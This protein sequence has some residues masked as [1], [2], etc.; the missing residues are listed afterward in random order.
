MEKL[1]P[2]VDLTKRLRKECPWDREQ[3]HESLK[4][5]LIEESYEV[6]EALE[7][8]D[9]GRMRE[10][11][12]DLLL[13]VLFHA[14]IAE[15]S[16]TFTLDDVASALMTKLVDRHPHIFGDTTVSGPG[17]VKENWEK[18]KM[19]EGRRSLLD[20][21]PRHLPG[22]L[23][24]LR[25]QEK[26][27]AGGFDWKRAGDV[28]GKVEEEMRE[29][30]GAVEA[31][32]TENIR[33]EFGDLLFSLVNYARFLKIDPE[34]ALRRTIGKFRDRFT[35]VEGELRKRGKTPAESTLTE[36]DILWNEAKN[37]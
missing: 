1:G 3:T 8:G 21:L 25:I 29:L 13:Q 4:P 36:M 28:F 19:R 35:Y 37:T 30:S 32:D 6:L 26:A 10:E 20:G 16:G 2:L 9:P 27:A 34:D 22:L 15:E 11:L 17:E 23:H 7:S 24:A 18:L 31:G 12:G 14:N 33:E 5:H